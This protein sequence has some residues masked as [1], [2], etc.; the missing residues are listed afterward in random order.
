M[1]EDEYQQL[2]IVGLEAERDRYKAALRDAAACTL[3]DDLCAEHGA[4]HHQLHTRLRAALEKE[5][6][7]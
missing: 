1:K 7:G 3:P 4:E 2:R 5:R 6:A